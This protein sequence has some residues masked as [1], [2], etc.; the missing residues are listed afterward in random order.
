MSSPP[1]ASRGPPPPLSLRRTPRIR[2][3]S[4]S[5]PPY[6]FSL[7][8][9]RVVAFLF[10]R[11]YYPSVC[12]FVN[13]VER[14][15]RARV[16]AMYAHIYVCVY[17]YTTA[18]AAAA[19]ASRAAAYWH[20]C[21]SPAM[22]IYA[23]RYIYTYICTSHKLSTRFSRARRTRRSDAHLPAVHFATGRSR[24]ARELSRCAIKRDESI[25]PDIPRAN[26]C[27]T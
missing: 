12:V 13:R 27:A 10:L 19:S 2:S 25:L 23:H 21:A 22:H 8:L 17:V 6:L 14:G 1:L 11:V 9:P 26:Q 4:L 20:A 7:R 16:S 5:N 24:S 18:A 15:S 3:V